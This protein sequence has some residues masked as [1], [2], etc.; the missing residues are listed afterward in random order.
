L[1]GSERAEEKV[2]H[3]SSVLL[4]IAVCFLLGA[5]LTEV[6]GDPTDGLAFYTFAFGAPVLLGI[7]LVIAAS[8]RRDVFGNLGLTGAIVLLV[9]SLSVDIVGFAAGLIGLTLI[10]AAVA[11]REPRL[12]PGVFLLGAGVLG[13]AVSI[14]STEAGYAI[15]IPVIAVGAGVLAATLRRLG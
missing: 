14:E 2:L 4:A 15:F 10:G 11:G 8:R 5:W 9:G 7:G 12:L 6:V 13:L 3:G 1:A